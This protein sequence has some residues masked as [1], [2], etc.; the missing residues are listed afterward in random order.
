[1]IKSLIIIDDFVDDP[2]VVREAALLQNYP[3][4]D[5]PTTYPGNDSAQRLIFNGFDERMNS[6]ES[7]KPSPSV[8]LIK[9]LLPKN[10]SVLSSSM[11]PSVS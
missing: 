6:A 7:F 3:A 9:G 10:I 2:K 8:S 5:K 11:S 4:R 1:M